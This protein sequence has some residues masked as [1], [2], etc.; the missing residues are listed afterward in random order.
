MAQETDQI[1]DDFWEKWYSASELWQPELL[2]ELRFKDLAKEGFEGIL[3][4][5]VNS[6]LVDL[7][8]FMEKRKR[9]VR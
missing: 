2:K 4:T 3:L 6:Y 5:L 9:T 7:A 8:E 1:K